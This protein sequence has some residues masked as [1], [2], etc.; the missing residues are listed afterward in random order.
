MLTFWY[1]FATYFV[2]LERR[3]CEDKETSTNPNTTLD[4]TKLVHPYKNRNDTQIQNTLLL[5]RYNTMETTATNTRK[6]KLKKLQNTWVKMKTLFPPFKIMKRK[7]DKSQ[8][9]DSDN[10]DN[11]SYDAYEDLPRLNGYIETE[12]HVP[13]YYRDEWVI[14]TMEGGEQ[15]G[16][17]KY[18]L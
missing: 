10:S 18:E 5:F 17:Y 16:I 3:G 14:E 1:D 4:E 9:S 8:G 12:I 2:R 15:T 7:R 11:E 6:N 13:S